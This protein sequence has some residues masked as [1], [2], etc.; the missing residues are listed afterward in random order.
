[1]RRRQAPTGLAAAAQYSDMQAINAG[2]HHDDRGLSQA[3]RQANFFSKLSSKF[4]SSKRYESNEL[5]R[6]E[7]W[8]SRHRYIL[9]P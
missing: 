5:L 4:S 8:K 3:A 1:M 7:S 6:S 9:K 2:S